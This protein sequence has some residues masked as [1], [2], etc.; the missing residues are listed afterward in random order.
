MKRWLSF[1]MAGGFALPVGAHETFV[2]EMVSMNE[3]RSLD[4]ELRPT[5]RVD[6]FT[7]ESNKNIEFTDTI[8][9]IDLN[10]RW[11]PVEKW[12]TLLEIPQVGDKLEQA[13]GGSSSSNSESGIGQVILGGKYSFRESAGAAVRLELPTGDEKDGLGEGTNIG[14]ALLGEKEW[15]ACRL[16]GNLG[17]LLKGKYESA[18]N[19][20][21][22][23][24]DV[25][26]LNAAVAHERWG[27]NWI[28]EVNVNLLGKEEVNSLAVAD[29]DGAAV[30][31][32]VGA[33]KDINDN[34]NL[35]GALVFGVGDE[36]T[37]SFDLARGAGDYKIVLAAA[38]KF[39]Y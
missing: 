6:E 12:E 8:T 22:D 1:L 19:T 31:L 10:L 16:I 17:Y 21:V 15:G 37:R 30:D 18:P 26:Q 13:G 29:S 28:G 36:Q 4:L 27:L 24:G 39:K 33:G 11:V 7:F 20:D 23:P 14:L 32:L 35:K 9:R 2:T 34:W 3:A 25:I 5:Y 38:Y